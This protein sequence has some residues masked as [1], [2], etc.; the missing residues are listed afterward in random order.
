M[1]DRLK[2]KI[3]FAIQNGD[4]LAMRIAVTILLNSGCNRFSGHPEICLP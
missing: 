1:L 2:D 4:W 3:Y